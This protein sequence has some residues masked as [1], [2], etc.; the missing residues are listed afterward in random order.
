ML[1]PG[2]SYEKELIDKIVY[3]ENIVLFYSGSKG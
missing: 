2:K 3:D 1:S